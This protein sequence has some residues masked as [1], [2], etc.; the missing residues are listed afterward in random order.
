MPSTTSRDVSDLVLARLSGQGD[1]QAFEE[2]FARH[3]PSTFRYALH[4]LDG[5]DAL[6]ADATQDAWVK[7]WLGMAGF[8]GQA[9][10]RTWVFTI[11]AREVADIRRRHRPLVVDH[12]VLAQIEAS[13]VSQ[14]AAESEHLQPSA[15][16][17]ALDAELWATLSLALAEL[18]WRQRATW[19]LRTF[20]DMSYDDIAGVLD[21][22][23]AVVRGQLHRAR[24]SL[25][26][27][28]EQ[29]R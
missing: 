25:A 27:R 19:L 20:E 17:E 4:M 11:V 15:E 22:T 2:L 1:A 6:A 10:V 16:R 23:P 21:T 26:I 18:P 28:M 14:R 5:D 7:A 3:F 29:W 24:R 12:S 8:R 13:R 9:Q